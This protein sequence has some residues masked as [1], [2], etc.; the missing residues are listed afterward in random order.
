MNFAVSR[1]IDNNAINA[2]FSGINEIKALD[3]SLMPSQ[4]RALMRKSQALI[5]LKPSK[6]TLMYY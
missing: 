5:S 3:F 2:I 6:I 1:V 4:A